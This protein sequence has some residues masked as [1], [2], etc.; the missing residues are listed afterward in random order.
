MADG[1]VI[2]VEKQLIAT[3]ARLR[4][5]KKAANEFQEALRKKLVLLIG[6][7]IGKRRGDVF[8]IDAKTIERAIDSLAILIELLLLEIKAIQNHADVM[9]LHKDR[10]VGDKIRL[11]RMVEGR[12]KEIRGL[13]VALLHERRDSRKK[14]KR[15]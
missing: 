14:R 10:L 15:Y 8:A 12:E 11:A 6:K 2:D 1:T 13:E 3:I 9:H 4:K 7:I 5:E